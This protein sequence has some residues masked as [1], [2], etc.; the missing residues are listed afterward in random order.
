MTRVFV[1]AATRSRLHD[2]DGVLEVCDE[3]GRTLGYF[4]PAT[5]QVA[6]SEVPRSPL[7]EDE[8]ELRRKDRSGRPLSEILERLG[9]S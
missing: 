5:V 6:S 3:S 8:V 9:R 2:L 1:D 4:H 7:N